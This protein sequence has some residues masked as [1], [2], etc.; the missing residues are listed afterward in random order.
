M[1]SV[2]EIYSRLLFFYLTPFPASGNHSGPAPILPLPPDVKACFVFS[3]YEALKWTLALLKRRARSYWLHAG[4]KWRLC[5]GF[6]SKTFHYFLGDYY[7]ILPLLLLFFAVTNNT[8]LSVCGTFRVPSDRR[9]LFACY[10]MSEP[11]V[12]FCVAVRSSATRGGW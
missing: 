4:G 2:G 12:C 8:G 11:P 6:G 5:L 7:L 10:P 3:A 9:E 1:L